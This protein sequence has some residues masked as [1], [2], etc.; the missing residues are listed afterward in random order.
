MNVRGEIVSGTECGPKG[1]GDPVNVTATILPEPERSTVGQISG[2]AVRSAQVAARVSRQC[3]TV[4][5]W[6]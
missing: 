4:A 6:A 5:G 2:G 3:L 1:V